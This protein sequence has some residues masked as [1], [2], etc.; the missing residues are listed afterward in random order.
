MNETQNKLTVTTPSDLEIVM[1]RDFDAPSALVFDVFTKPE[2]VVKWWG[3][4]EAAMP[5]CDIDLRVGGAYRFV[6]R[7]E[8]GTDHPFKGVYREI[9]RP[10]RLVHTQVYDV[11]PFNMF[12]AVVTF[13]LTESGGKTHMVETIRHATKE[14]RDGHLQS[15]MEEG[16]A[17]SLDRVD[18]LLGEL[19]K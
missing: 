7:D 9:D 3:C 19:Q 11:E 18:V 10:G 16:A 5:V 12:E 15:G 6:F 4:S 2:H 17:L 14:A 13:E 1:T 8:D